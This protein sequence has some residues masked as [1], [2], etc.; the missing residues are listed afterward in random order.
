MIRLRDHR[1]LGDCQI[2]A[3]GLPRRSESHAVAALPDVRLENQWQRPAPHVSLR[4]QRMHTLVDAPLLDQDRWNCPRWRQLVKN[5]ELRF[6]DQPTVRHAGIGDR[7]SVVSG[8]SIEVG[9][10]SGRT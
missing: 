1:L 10:H 2:L 4:A 3:D 8:K 7:K 5:V 6:T 9:Y